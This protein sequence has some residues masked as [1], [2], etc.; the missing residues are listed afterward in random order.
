M[1]TALQSLQ[2]TVEQHGKDLTTQRGADQPAEQPE[3]DQ[4]QCG[5]KGQRAVGE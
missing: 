1:A 5:T 3:H 4:Q 2:N